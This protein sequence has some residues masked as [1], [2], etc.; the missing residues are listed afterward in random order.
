M[1]KQYKIRA[2]E[3]ASL[4]PDIYYIYRSKKG[5]TY[6]LNGVSHSQLRFYNH[7]KKILEKDCQR[8]HAKVYIPNKRLGKHPKLSYKIIQPGLKSS[9][10]KKAKVVRI[11]TVTEDII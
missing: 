8:D 1:T 4:A 7:G 9:P 5:I 11:G 10:A 6:K 3:Y 2:S